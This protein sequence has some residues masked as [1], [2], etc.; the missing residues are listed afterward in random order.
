MRFFFA[1]VL[2]AAVCF[3]NGSLFGQSPAGLWESMRA[4]TPRNYV[5]G[6]T[7]EPIKIDGRGDEAAW[8]HAA[9]TEDFRD[10]EGDK[11][12]NPRFR[13]RAK[14]LWDDDFF[15][16]YAELDEPHVWGTITEKNKTMYHDND[17]EVFID[18]DGDTHNYYEFEMNANNAIW[19]LSLEKP[20]RDGGPI[21]NPDNLA[22]TKSAVYIRGT[23]NDARD[24]DQGWSVEIAFLWK[25]L[26]RFAG[27]AACPPREQDIWR[28]GFSRVEWLIDI[29]DGKYRNVAG[30][31]EDN[32]TWCAQ[33]VINMHCP[34]RW[35]FVQFTK[36]PASEAK[37]TPDPTWA[38]RELLTEIYHRQKAFHEKQKRYAATLAELG[39][40]P[41]ISARQLAK[42]IDLQSSK[43]GFVATATLKAAGGSPITF[44]VRQ[45]SR[46]WKGVP[47]QK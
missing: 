41:E 16:V 13:T 37:F 22:G 8:K 21:R 46:L 4:I 23:L 32:W 19:E 6:F 11:K 12:P 42:S 47:G 40:N 27:D 9:W 26:K 3:F 39:I 7:P 29:I 30:K 24:T 5:C 33:G 45:D 14:M 17:F 18:P 34:E 2:F 25:D 38:A 44:H 43:D 20:Y 31:P 15:Y 1:A 35:G 28:V 36:R 10:I